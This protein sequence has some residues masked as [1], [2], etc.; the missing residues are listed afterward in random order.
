MLTNIGL[1]IF[2][3]FVIAD[4]FRTDAETQRQKDRLKHLG[5][6]TDERHRIHK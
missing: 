6:M 4:Q 2:A 3:I 1:I 5:A